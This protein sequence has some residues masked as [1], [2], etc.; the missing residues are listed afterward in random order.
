[1]QKIE[2]VR[3]VYTEKALAPVLVVESVEAAVVVIMICK[4]PAPGS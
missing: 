2:S 1:M 3:G 4:K